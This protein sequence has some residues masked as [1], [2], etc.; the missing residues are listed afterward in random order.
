[1]KK[2]LSALW[3][4]TLIAIEARA[5]CDYNK[6]TNTI[7]VWDWRQEFYQ[8]MYVIGE[9]NQPYYSIP[10]ATPGTGVPS[11]FI[12]PPGGSTNV[13]LQRFY[14]QYAQTNSLAS[15]DCQ[16][17]DGWELLAK[18]FGTALVPTNTP[19]FALYNRYTGMVRAFFLMAQDPQ[20]TQNG[21]LVKMFHQVRQ[22]H[23][24]RETG[25]LSHLFPVTK[26]IENFIKG[27]VMTS[28][29][30][31]VSQRGYWLF[32]DFPMAYDPC[33][34]NFESKIRFEIETTQNMNI[35]LNGDIVGYFTQSVANT[36]GNVNSKE[37]I[38]NV[39]GNIVKSGNKSFESW[40]KAVAEIE[41]FANKQDIDLQNQI[42]FGTT[43]MKNLLSTV[44]YLGA[45]F[46]VMDYFQSLDKG[47]GNASP[48]QFG[49]NLKFQGNGSI[50]QTNSFGVYTYWTPGSNQNS[51]T[52]KTIYD[53]PLGVVS[54]LK[55]IKLE[56]VDYY[57]RAN[58]Q[59][60]SFSPIRQYKIAEPVKFALNPSSGLE[61]IEIQ[62]SL[63][64]RYKPMSKH[65][66][67]FFLDNSAKFGNFFTRPVGFINTPKF[68]DKVASV[69]LETEMLTYNTNNDSVLVS[70]RTP[71]VPLSCFDNT[72]VFLHR[73]SIDNNNPHVLDS[74]LGF[75]V[76]F[77][78]KARVISQP[79][80]EVV[81]LQ[82]YFVDEYPS[83]LNDGSNSHRWEE[84]DD[85]SQLPTFQSANGWNPAMPAPYALAKIDE[86]IQNT[87]TS[88]GLS[89]MRN[90]TLGQNLTI[91]STSPITFKAGNQITVEQNTYIGS[92]T[93]LLIGLPN[94]DCDY[95][96]R[97]MQYTQDEIKAFCSQGGI[98]D[99]HTMS[100]KGFEI[101]DRANHQ[102]NNVEFIDIAVVNPFDN[103]ISI[104]YSLLHDGPVTIKLYS[105]TGKALFESKLSKNVK[106]SYSENIDVSNYNL[107]EGVY[108]MEIKSQQSN[109]KRVK[110][111][112]TR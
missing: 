30:Y 58:D 17:G 106:G 108:I 20:T 105:L 60:I 53:N 14:N 47:S 98:Y 70:I 72:S 112:K 110:L 88:I 38:F 103:S 57:N 4:L 15:V 7:S 61:I 55:P 44:P 36:P 85:N 89:V 65:V 63:V 49:A 46:G 93:T 11:P 54:F 16:P 111:I 1:M 91:T 25:I 86:H 23:Q 67:D 39:A 31:Y 33:V 76:K 95:N 109:V 82:T 80:K 27:G 19:F 34:C 18:E 107:P 73:K 13:N 50:S 92:E 68:T 21:A 79:D 64:M 62:A 90:L 84:W 83:A 43:N 104:F 99:N 74:Y 5:Q 9:P 35:T 22:G 94:V 66:F 45:A 3:L 75:V 81:F 41:K 69:G 97:P 101:E 78:I 2:I 12:P 29:N 40:A 59:Y 28:P 102:I 87:S 100:K 6:S 37:N 48:M 71:Y 42:L 26:T 8:D 10:G 51:Q 56:Y 96:V 32:A 52:E 24:D 77:I